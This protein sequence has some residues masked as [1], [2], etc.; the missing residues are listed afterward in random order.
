LFFYYA[1]AKDSFAFYKSE[2][3]P[4]ISSHHIPVQIQRVHFDCDLTGI[5]PARTGTFK[6]AL[7]ASL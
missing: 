1:Q 4:K 2:D 5:K 6:A 3:I 7:F